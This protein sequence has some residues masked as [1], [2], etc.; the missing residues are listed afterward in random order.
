MPQIFITI[1][2]LLVTYWGKIPGFWQGV[3]AGMTGNT[4]YDFIKSGNAAALSKYLYSVASESVMQ[5]IYTIV[6]NFI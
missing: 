5:Q 2:R 1:G 6:K 3:I 4:I